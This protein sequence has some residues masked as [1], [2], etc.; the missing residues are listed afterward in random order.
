M[1]VIEI[2][3]TEIWYEDTGGSGETVLFHHGYTGS[4]DTWPPVI[5]RLGDERRYVLMDGRGAGDSGRPDDGR[6]TLEQYTADVIRLVDALGI[7]TFTYVG[8]SM[9]GGIGFLLG[10]E[11]GDRL[12]RLVL[13]APIPSGGI[14]TPPELR[15]EALALWNDGNEDELLRQRMM[16]AARPEAID[17]Q[18]VKAGV[19]RTLSVSPGHYEQSWESM[20]A[21]D[22]TER[23]GELRTPT[24]I[25]AG[26]ADGLAKANVEDYLRLPKVTLQVFNRVGHSIP[27]E[28][29]DEFAAVLSDFFDNGLVTAGVLAKRIANG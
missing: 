24:L 15:D 13:V 22:V 26:A 18:R 1:P 2:N 16:G 19:A 11:H 10:L 4:H 12:D 28:V 5:E 20:Q 17:E 8:H 23:L 14:A 27:S 3:G 7:D 25:I 29:P 21:F 6:Y 9:G